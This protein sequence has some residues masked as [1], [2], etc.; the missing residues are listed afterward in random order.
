M[1]K[2]IISILL[3]SMMFLP[4]FKISANDDGIT[5]QT[6]TVSTSR[7]K[8]I[9][10]QDAYIPLASVNNLD[11]ESLLNPEDIFIDKD[12]NIFIAD[13]GN[14]RIVKYNLE[15]DEIVVIGEGFLRE[16]KGVHVDEKGN[17]YVADYGHKKAFKFSFSSETLTYEVTSTYEKPVN[18]PYFKESDPFDPTKIVTDK[19]GNVYLLLAAN[20]NGLAE[21]KNDG[22][23]FGFFG[24][25]R[26]PNTFENIVKS[27]LFDENQRRKWF[28]MI[29]KPVY[30]MTIDNNGLIATITKDETG[31]LKLNIANLIFSKSDW[32]RDNFEDITVGP[33]NNLFA[34]SKDG[35]IYE[36]TEEGQLLFIFSGPD[37]NFQVGR[38]S[39]A[40][41]IAVDSKNNLYALD[42]KNSRLEIFSPTIFA[43]LIHEAIDYY[44][45]GL[46]QESKDPWESVLKMNKHFDLAL[47]GL[48]DAYYALGDYE[49]AMYYYELS[50]DVD[51]YSNAYWEVRNN[52][53]LNS[54][55]IIVYVLIVL[56]VLSIV[57]KFVNI[58]RYIKAPFKKADKYLSKFKVY[59]ETKYN[60]KLIKSPSDSFYGIK[61][62]NKV[63]NLTATIMFLLFFISYLIYIY[64]TKFTFNNRIV[65]EI[66]IFNQT[67]MVFVPMLLWVFSNYL[68]SS[69]KDGEGSL[70]NVY[71]GSIYSLLPMTITFPILVILSHILTLN[72]A[73]IFD[74]IL[75]IG[76][77]LSVFYLI[78]MVK[79]I[80]FYDLRPTIKNIFISIFTG[81]MILVMVVI[82]YILLNEVFTIVIDVI[83]E[84]TSRA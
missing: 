64:F 79:E 10:T 17:L 49:E 68:V 77:G 37:Y 73:F 20:T 63:S 38:F 43:N 47:K 75:Y 44:Q 58:G 48:G 32:G 14:K 6:F 76:I 35:Y 4:V 67:L 56:I 27:L 50:R 25:N 71:Q 36:Y 23:F 29:P 8:M 28:K 22:E 46:Y 26:L 80:H 2:I 78:Y 3:L 7:R 11:K 54:A 42:Q 12:D 19:G 31:Y 81:L 39:S 83:K 55:P 61:R 74:S 51:G 16:P 70:S 15:A 9:P 40:S 1:K 18:S 84:V 53:L 52:S 5:Y 45:K 57:N 33:N 72:E 62:E 66:S 82:I 34:I 41:G 69:I 59:K 21:F 65:Q 30:N 60:F 24:G 13:T